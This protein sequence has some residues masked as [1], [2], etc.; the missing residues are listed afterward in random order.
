VRLA[1]TL[2]W[3]EVPTGFLALEGMLFEN[4]FRLLVVIAIV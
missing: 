1:A 4:L 3:L 2:S